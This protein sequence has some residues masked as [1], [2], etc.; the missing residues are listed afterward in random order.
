MVLAMQHCGPLQP[1]E[2]RRFG[3]SCVADLLAQPLR[4]DLLQ[5]EGLLVA[6]TP[7]LVDQATSSAPEGLHQQVLV[8]NELPDR[9]HHRL[10][11]GLDCQGQQK[12]LGDAAPSQLLLEFA[13]TEDPKRAGHLF[14]FLGIHA[15]ND[16]R[17]AWAPLFGQL[18]QNVGAQHDDPHCSA[19]FP[20]RLQGGKGRRGEPASRRG[21]G[22][23]ALPPL[24]DHGLQRLAWGLRAPRL[25]HIAFA[26]VDL[27]DRGGVG[28]GVGLLAG[29]VGGIGI[30][31]LLQLPPLLF[32][33]QRFHDRRLETRLGGLCGLL[34]RYADRHLPL[35]QR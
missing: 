32:N 9:G 20:G 7:C 17:I 30:R 29:L 26:T 19:L 34:S 28:R 6:H 15:Q 23:R 4:V 1:L 5:R 27:G 10:A 3:F 2:Q 33:G 18:L 11:Q 25:Q 14:E 31:G 16:V 35:T 12:G 21:G 13:F 8:G 24:L 22:D